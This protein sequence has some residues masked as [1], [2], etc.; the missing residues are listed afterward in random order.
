MN[1]AN[2]LHSSSAGNHQTLA[3]ILQY[4]A[5]HQPEK[6]AYT[7]LADGETEE[8]SLTFAQLDQRARL[9]AA[10]MQACAQPGDRALLVYHA[11][12]EYVA[13]F[14]GCLYAG[15][16]AVPAYPPRPNGN[17]DRLLAIVNDCQAKVILG[18]SDVVR[19]L[20][21]K[22]PQLT[23]PETL[24]WIETE[25]LAELAPGAVESWRK[26]ELRSESIA[27]LQ[28]TSGSTAA[29][30]GVMVSY[31]NLAH[32]QQIMAEAFGANE[33]TVFVSWL[34]IYHDMGL[35]GFIFPTIFCGARCVFMA[36]AA[37]LRQPAAW[38]RAIS[39]YK[40]TISAGPN[41][42]F[43]LCVNKINTESENLDLSSLE[44]LINGAEPIRTSSMLQFMKVFEPCGLRRGAIRAAYGL[45]EATLMVSTRGI[46]ESALKNF[47]RAALEQGRAIEVMNI[48]GDSRF[49]VSCGVSRNRIAIVDP[50]TLRICEAGQTG[51]I[52]VA[53]PIVA[54][55]YWNNPHATEST[56][57]GQMAGTDERPF[58]RTGDLGFLHQEQ[59]FVTGRSKDLIIIN[60]RN[61]YPQDIELTVE[62]SHSA[63]RSGFGAAFSIEV[64]CVE[65]LIVVY[66]I[67]RSRIRRLNFEEV[68]L[69]IREAVA[70]RHE[71]EVHA[72]AF[73]KPG[74]I[75][76]TSSGKIQRSLCRKKYLAGELDVIEKQAGPSAAGETRSVVKDQSGMDFSLFYFSSNEAEFQQ[77]KYRLLLEGAKFADE[78]SFAAVW[79]PE[80]HFHA[81][82]GIYPNPSVLASALAVTT[83][84]I[85]IRAGS[86]V[87]PLHNPILVA[88]E[89]AVV[90]NLSGGRVD[91]AF[92]RGWNPNDFVLSP[93]SYPNSVQVLYRDLEIVRRLW[94]G[95][96]ITMPN[97][98]GK[99]TQV[100]I[101]PLPQQK[102]LPVWIT[103]SGGPERFV[104]AGESGWNVL[105]ALLF[106]SPEELG[107]KIAAYRKA[108]ARHG[109]DPQT[110]HVTLMLH[111]FLG[112]DE[113]K[114]KE[115]VRGPFIEYLKSSIDLWQQGSKNLNDLSEEERGKV[116]EFAF[117][118]YYHTSGLF[119]TPETCFSMVQNLRSVGVNEIA[120]LLDFGV[121]TEAVLNGLEYL[122]KLKDRCAGTSGTKKQISVSAVRETR[123]QETWLTADT[124]KRGQEANPQ[125][126]PE[127]DID[128]HATHTSRRDITES[129]EV[130][131]WIRRA[132]VDGI[133]LAT[134]TA[135][136][137]ISY[138]KNFFSL[139]INSLRAV[140]IIDNIQNKFGLKL[141]PTLLFEFPTVD[142]LTLALSQAHGA[143]L[144]ERMSGAIPAPAA[145]PP[146]PE[147]AVKLNCMPA[148]E[149][150]KKTSGDIAIIGMACRFPG[151]PDL[152]SFWEL[153]VNGRDAVT[154]VPADH[155]DWRSFYDS[156]PDAERKT[157]S[158]WGGFL[159]GID[160]FD[161]AF[162]N[163][164][165]REARLID[166][167]QRI[168]LETAWHA[169]EHSGYSPESLADVPVG[170]FVGASYNGYYQKIQAGLRQSDHSAGTGNQNAIIANRVSFFLN[171]HGPSLLVDTLCSSSLIAVHLACNSLKTGECLIAVAGGVNILLSPENYVAMSR[172]KAHSPDGRCKAF[173]HRAN[174]ICFGEGAGAVILKPLEQALQDGDTIHAVIKASAI[175][176]GGQTNGL[177]APNPQAQAQLVRRA[178]DT[179]GISAESIS[180]IEAHGT[181]TSLG[182]PIEVE[183]LTKAFRHFTSK[184]QFCAI[185]SVKTNIGHLESAAGMAGII[186]VVLAMQHR[187]LP[188]TLHFQ[189][190]NPLISFADSPFRVQRELTGWSREG[191]L[192]AGVSSF[193][194]GGSNAHV[195]LEQG[196]RS[197][198]VEQRPEHPAQI[199]TLSA[200]TGASLK[201]LAA[202]YRSFLDSAQNVSLNDLCFTVTSGRSHFSHRLAAVTTD[203]PSLKEM[204]TE[205]VAGRTPAEMLVG[206]LRE[207][208]KPQIAFL[209]TGQ[210]SQY[211]GMGRQLYE[212]NATFRD[213][214]DRCD[215]ALRNR[216]KQPLAFPL[217]S[218][219]AGNLPANAVSAQ[220]TLFALEYSLTELWKSWGVTPDFVMGHSLGEYAAAVA[221]GVLG[222]EDGL[223]L[224]AERAQLMQEHALQGGMMAAVFAGQDVL[225]EHLARHGDHASI[226]AVNGPRHVVISGREA[227]VQEILEALRANGIASEVL[228]VTHAF[229][230]PLLDPML[231]YFE[232]AARKFQFQAPG[233]PLVSN[234]T[235][236]FIGPG[237]M[238]HVEVQ[239][240]A[241]W[242]RHMR[243][244]VQ[245]L[246][247]IQTLVERGC[248]LFIEIGPT[249]SLLGIARRCTRAE[250][251]TWLPSLTS[252][253]S[254]W[255]VLLHSLGELY[256]RGVPVNWNAFNANAAGHRIAL[257]A[258]PFERQ[259]FWADVVEPAAHAHQT[260][261]TNSLES[262]ILPRVSEELKTS[263]LIDR[264]NQAPRRQDH[265][266]LLLRKS[267]A[268]FLEM[269]ESEIDDQKSF[270]ELGSDSLVLIE[271]VQA[272]QQTFDVKLSI[273]QLFEELNTLRKVA[274][275]I[276]QRLP[277]NARFEGWPHAEK[278]ASTAAIPSSGRD[279]EAQSA[280]VGQP[281]FNNTSAR[282]QDATTE[283]MA[284][285][286]GQSVLERIVAQQLAAMTQLMQQQ[287]LAATQH[288]PGAPAAAQMS[289]PR[290]VL[291]LATANGNVEKLASAG[292]RVDA[293]IA[294][295]QPWVPY[296]PLNPGS[297]DELTP[298]QQKYLKRF[299]AEYAARTK[300]SKETTQEYRSHHADLRAAMSFRLCTK[301]IRYPIV[302][303]RSQGATLWD[304]DDNQYV[305]YTMGYGVN[306][307]GHNPPFVMEA[308]QQQLAKGIHV[309]PQSELAGEVA[310]LFCEI[311]GM[312]RATFCNSGTEAVMA[313]L[314]VARVS[315]GRTKVAIFAGSYHGTSDG[316]LVT[317]QMIDGELRAVPMIPGIPPGMVEEL[318]VLNY[319]SARSLAMLKAA[320]HEFAAVL[321]EPVQ[322]RKP[323]LQPVEFLRQLRTITEDAG[324]LLIFD[325]VITGFR[326]HSKGAQGWF[327][328]QADLATY[329]KIVGGGLPIGV[330]AG[331][332]E[333]MDSIDGGMWGF[334]DDSVPAAKTTLYTGTFC[335]HPLAMAA[336]KAVLL[337]LKRSGPELFAR[338]NSQTEHLAQRLNRVF[339]QAQA[340][341]QTVRFGSLFRLGG[342]LQLMATDALDLLY[343]H[344]IHNGVY[345]WEGRN[346]FLSTAH[347][348][349]EL[350][351]LVDVMKRVVGELQDAGFLPAPPS[352]SSIEEGGAAGKHSPSTAKPA[353]DGRRPAKPVI[354]PTLDAQKELL[355]FSRG[356]E[357][358]S[359]SYNQSVAVRLRGPFALASLQHAL[360]EVMRR[361]EALRTVFSSGEEF[362]Q[363]LP[364]P[365]LPL[366]QIDLAAKDA[367]AQALAINEWMGEEAQRPF[368]LDTAPLWRVTVLTLNQGDHLLVITVHH[369]IADGWSIGI[370]LHEISVLYSF[371]AQGKH[372]ELAEPMGIR[373]YAE[374]LQE[375]SAKPEMEVAE[376]Y[377][378]Q[379]LLNDA[380]A[381]NLPLDYPRSIA[382][383]GNRLAKT[384]DASLASQI[385]ALNAHLGSTLF[386]TLLAAYQVF[387]SRLTGQNDLVTVVPVANQLRMK[388]SYLIGD[389]SNL[390]AVRGVISPESTFADCVQVVKKLLLE[391]N[392]HQLYP[393]A[394]LIRKLKPQRDPSRW[395]FFNID[396]PISSPRF[397]G[398]VAEDAPFP[399]RYTNFDFGLNVTVL[400]GKIDFTF[401]Y[402]TAL[403]N[404]ETI[405]RWSGHF[406]DLLRQVVASP[407][408][409]IASLPVYSA[410][411]EPIR[412]TQDLEA[413]YVG[414]GTPAEQL[415]ADIWKE[416]LAVDRVSILADF[417]ELGGHSLLATQIISRIR[418]TFGTEIGLD[419]LFQHSS[420]AA[421]ARYLESGPQGEEGVKESVIAPI[422]RDQALPL[423]FTQ[424][425]LWLIEQID[426]GNTAYNMIGGLHFR[427]PLNISALQ[428]S[429]NEVIK[430]HDSLRTSFRTVDGEPVQH[431]HPELALDI[432]YV[433]LTQ[434][435]SAPADTIIKAQG[436][437]LARQSFKLT[438]APLLRLRL[439]KLDNDDYGL[440]VTIH[441]IISDGWSMGVLLKEM[442]SLYGGLFSGKPSP[443]PALPIQ[444][445]DYAAWQRQSLQGA[446]LDS[447]IKWWVQQLQ[448]VPTFLNLP[449]DRP[450]VAKPGFRGAH[451]PF[452]F[453]VELSEG[454][455]WLS[456]QEGVTVFMTLLAGLSIVLSRYSAQDEFIVGTDIANRTRVETENLIGCFVNLL[457]LR[458]NLG[459]DPEV[460]EYL[461][462][463]RKHTLGAYAHQDVPFDQL[464]RELRPERAL[465]STP[466]VQV[467]C[468]LQNVPFAVEQI[469]MLSMEV[470]PIEMETAEFELILSVEDAPGA[471]FGTLGFSTDL[472]DG[473]RIQAMLAHLQ[474]A[475]KQMIDNP[476]RRLSSLSMLTENEKSQHATANADAQ[477]SQKDLDKLLLKFS[478]A[479]GK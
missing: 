333:C 444:F 271:S 82:G 284:T 439:L 146:R 206:H 270:L 281:V 318:V 113:R 97:G 119:G 77:Q 382:R 153:L 212:T 116:M 130:M 210:G 471:F 21:L 266:I 391:C 290:Q 372:C 75:P 472:F 459:G 433:D 44:A 30:K 65:R 182:D 223:Q 202:N 121:E 24:K 99:D 338:L 215:A 194:I 54:Q 166:P 168:M 159:E 6:I 118:R 436:Q 393:F 178:L 195:I 177:L 305:D 311:S 355:L 410:L 321:V 115:Q 241:Y 387:L 79:V 219:E 409:V 262:H 95:E 123:N 405:Q 278:T 479:S 31:A 122:N 55:G 428:D 151:A 42:A 292:N 354:L 10:T 446:A 449:T 73:L 276:D 348:T 437:A 369:V 133:A 392:D 458:V 72:I 301:E 328:I 380:P 426:P 390:M 349:E 57:Q 160:L 441:H 465:T 92:A 53:S 145:A 70:M 170:V 102:E 141:S 63:L 474:T 25:S 180:Y 28:Y 306:L 8:G 184:K 265:L 4:R 110:G 240:A 49:L 96:S 2:H 12:I 16:I 353:D 74:N 131:A 404:T 209:F 164:S 176:H 139:G 398:L 282:S 142:Q 388:N 19:Q 100:R 14:F 51:E 35:I 394:Q 152:E 304:I 272:I 205:F 448:D 217:S 94:R 291:P 128:A 69:G 162:F 425:R 5:V 463:I 389:C 251:L 351:S 101:Y 86:V 213:A 396:R 312:E 103:C 197:R 203:A 289:A 383:Y 347:T 286:Q 71:A 377:W 350:D 416:V 445:P 18:S 208:E 138:S 88:E 322:S 457:P 156:N 249:A 319:G 87:L 193:G 412:E 61:L 254:D 295:A 90:D 373:D 224:V 232:A 1:R 132:I 173:D 468:V 268:K 171:L 147:N 450:R 89:W 154:E 216:L 299:I 134:E 172:M 247:G 310:S 64:E 214:M 359:L 294:A 379:E 339:E 127:K 136:G 460:R 297:M 105:T 467:L 418:E 442:V 269:H 233:I 137:A 303:V 325:E 204:L 163:I 199:F 179:A 36:P 267:M 196:P 211:A 275:Y 248:K 244:P 225:N 66:E 335:K 309:G 403:F 39:K 253:K 29:P 334:G 371:H 420:I 414:P 454:I 327:G 135:P 343:Y 429:L 285:S 399:I 26:P 288:L 400:H 417:F 124:V 78:H 280:Q 366:Q 341:I 361:H 273:R 157:Y 261:E 76:K 411:T 435:P 175:N 186:K 324:V 340:P 20:L 58:L 33:S 47:D 56:F 207:N 376:R 330:L 323:D 220:T 452:V 397:H 415:L 93:E 183:G 41:F 364:E 352:G 453:S 104:E 50:E 337:E 250:G 342:P 287:V 140:E 386:M 201:M 222:L 430:R 360:N 161:A 320:I 228:K 401:D 15:I 362:Q 3:D 165:P 236:K 114:V 226:A 456:R 296:Q 148:V 293:T 9:I 221:A 365:R 227:V 466:L 434:G 189:K 329:G 316:V 478:A 374:F 424:R 473:T 62:Q 421:L 381:V 367:G 91:L 461:R 257:P 283:T 109:H 451:Q 336:A 413:P 60:G 302:G 174:G 462:R 345:V 191:L 419:S 237:F 274:E 358:A 67:E 469:P 68:A 298:S 85:R 370:L 368:Q 27:F 38:L 187:Q 238:E 384:L 475:L 45:A 259:R 52:W 356:S 59:L 230:S 117:E 408:T 158:R 255:E 84:H 363:V 7:F 126:Q 256:V 23:E 108:R 200:K 423:S 111:T 83:K 48:D 235:G 198:R 106:Q 464:V 246:S 239:N 125:S 470:V 315:T 406:E 181:G 120:C 422:P 260:P 308:I 34:P 264:N 11:G 263:V 231:A 17:L 112:D 188:P 277:E 242:R 252:G 344:L 455:R 169:F 43:D 192:R 80:R 378:L 307:F 32:N 476:E 22:L 332:A 129:P 402:K 143:H 432:D 107:L 385:T 98:K 258:Y 190:A 313:A 218:D 243:E 185:G 155:W 279:K 407:D 37:F 326:A 144:R 40:A 395:P 375:E 427:G 440:V 13:A 447:Q 300:K 331:K 346:W 234:L 314:R 477:L 443:L 46:D 81:F 167:Q 149:D 431:V 357:T 245:F 150:H 229:H 438:D 317:T